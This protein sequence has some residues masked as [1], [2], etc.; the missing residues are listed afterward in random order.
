[1]RAELYEAVRW[2]MT[3]MLERCVAVVTKR[4]RLLA[5]VWGVAI[6]VSLPLAAQENKHLSNGGFVSPGSESAKVS[7]ALPQFSKYNAD[8][9]IVVLS[10]RRELNAQPVLLAQLQR[11]LKIV[12]GVRGVSVTPKAL[13]SAEEQ[14]ALLPALALPL[15]TSDSEDAQD[16]L[17]VTLRGKLSPGKTNP[18]GVTT[19]FLG[20]AA[21]FAAL[22]ELSKKDLIKAESV[23]LPL[24]LVVLLLVFGAFAAAALPLGLGV[25]AIVVSGAA[26]YLLSLISPV[27]IFASNMASLLGIGVAVDYSLFM[28]SRYQRELRGGAT[29]EEA[30]TTA[31]RTSG[32][33]IVISGL[34]VLVSLAALFLVN[35][36]VVRSMAAAA[37]MVVLVAVA[38]ALT[39]TPPVMRRYGNRYAPEDRLFTRLRRRWRPQSAATTS[40]E[41]WSRW[42]RQVM[43]RPALAVVGST[44]VLLVIAIPALSIKIDDAALNQF[45]SSADVV[46]G[47]RVLNDTFGPGVAGPIQVVVT[48]PPGA[49]PQ[50]RATAQQSAEAILR[51]HSQLKPP[52]VEA[53]A[54]GRSLLI[55]AVPRVAPDSETG[56]RIISEVRSQF[57]HGIGTE[58][59]VGGSIAQIQDYNSDVTGSLWRV[60]LAIGIL[61]FLLLVFLLRSIVLPLKA[62]LMTALTVAASYGVLV[63]FFQWRWFD[64][65]IGSG[66]RYVGTLTPP[67]VLALTFGLSMDYQIFLL[68]RI[69]EEYRRTGDN[70]LAVER[71]LASSAATITSAAVI[72]IVVFLA[73]AFVSMPS[74]Q[75]LGVGLAFAIAVDATLVR[76]VLV[77]A[78]MQLL[79]RWNWWFPFHTAT[80]PDAPD[81]PPPPA[82]LAGVVRD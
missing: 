79:G 62:V 69:K 25:V 10:S 54:D 45:P 78:A 9:L 50:A 26:L 7:A 52:K 49:S 5:I 43:H 65:L 16:N 1:M 57:R 44:A 77:P 58:A 11:V 24:V 12:Q 75:E 70:A 66:P 55:T 47:T 35:S 38:G 31:M 4:G 6:I 40:D 36:T 46:A 51:S 81:A 64:A 30:M 13:N 23:G 28:L 22:D 34:T 27:S 63:V 42:A 19:Y 17:A 56:H 73:F 33:A 80:A 72:M 37:V 82:R 14:S 48:L 15:H 53:S 39:L 41:F 3:S 21:L 67:F 2:E 20:Q 71:G 29:Q 68:T 32:Y 61:T 76:L 74:I 60:G 18:E 59:A 8:A